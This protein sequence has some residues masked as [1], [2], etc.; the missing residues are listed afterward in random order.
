MKIVYSI[1]LLFLSIEGKSQV[2]VSFTTVASNTTNSII[3]MYFSND[4][5]GF[6]VTHVG[7]IFQTTNG[8]DQWTLIHA[9]SIFETV[10]LSVHN[11]N[12]NLVSTT[13]SVFCHINSPSNTECIR[14]KSSISNIH[15]SKDTINHTVRRPIFWSNKIWDTRM[16]SEKL[17]SL[18]TNENNVIVGVYELNTNGSTMSGASWSK[19]YYT[20][21][22]GENWTEKSFAN[23][24]L[25]S[26]PFQ[27]FVEGDTMYAITNYPTMVYKSY[28]SGLTWNTIGLPPA[29]FK[30]YKTHLFGFNLANENTIYITD[31]DGNIQYQDTVQNQIINYYFNDNNNGFLMGKNGMLLKVSTAINLG[32]ENENDQLNLQIYPNPALDKIYLDL[33]NDILIQSIKLFDIT[34]KLIREF[35]ESQTSLDISDLISGNYIIRVSTNTSVFIQKVQKE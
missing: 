23:N 35:H 28:N 31:L 3:D 24:P 13:D 17:Q 9:D 4:S 16:V 8:G 21:D 22:E 26:T 15:F 27:S 10:E 18:F 30:M 14:L 7:E 29:Y 6:Y 32:L 12:L 33:D 20:N 34:G 5:I 25:N 2:N 11:G 1:L 19:L